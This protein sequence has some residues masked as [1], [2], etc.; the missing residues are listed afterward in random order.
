MYSSRRRVP[1]GAKSATAC[2]TSL[3]VA[4]EIILADF[5]LTVSTLTAKPPNL[6]PWQIFRLCGIHK[7]NRVR[8]HEAK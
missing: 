1:G 2:I 5:N 6:I 8:W 4:G 3:R 7:H